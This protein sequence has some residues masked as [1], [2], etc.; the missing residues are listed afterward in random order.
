MMNEIMDKCVLVDVLD[1]THKT[2]KEVSRREGVIK[3]IQKEIS[4]K[5]KVDIGNDNS[6]YSR[7]RLD[8]SFSSYDGINTRESDV[9]VDF[10]KSR[11]KTGIVSIKDAE[12]TINVLESDITQT[13]KSG[14]SCAFA[15]KDIDIK[16]SLNTAVSNISLDMISSNSYDYVVEGDDILIGS[17]H[18]SGP[19]TL[20]IPSK[21]YMK[22]YI[23]LSFKNTSSI[24]IDNVLV[25]DSA[26]N[27]DGII[28][29]TKKNIYG[30]TS[31]IPVTTDG[32]GTRTFLG[33]L[34]SIGDIVY[35]DASLPVK[36]ATDNAHK[37]NL[38]SASSI[39]GD[40]HK[41]LYVLKQL[42][43]KKNNLD[44]VNVYRGYARF[45]ETL[46]NGAFVND[47]LSMVD[48]KP[49]DVVYKKYVDIDRTNIT[50]VAG[51]LILL[52][53]TVYVD[54]ATVIT[55]PIPSGGKNFKWR[56]AID[57]NTVKDQGGFISYELSKG[58]NNVELTFYLYKEEDTSVYTDTITQSFNLRQYSDLI[59][60]YKLSRGN[61]DKVNLYSEFFCISSDK[62]LVG[63]FKDWDSFLV[64]FDDY[65]I[66][67]YHRFS[68]GRQYVVATVKVILTSEISYVKHIYIE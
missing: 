27:T 66:S 49:S 28:T 19:L 41:G 33:L 45:K 7:N 54:K 26:N 50:L 13:L 14:S 21:H 46:I 62:V 67:P 32:Y 12:F 59:F 9:F 25:Y 35:F 36:L 37:S 52:T 16:I 24:Q 4:S 48:Y 40:K 60:D 31:I 65:I 61:I 43:G 57:G 23:R 64:T 51:D 30:S 29:T 8:V 42:S 58:N 56:L 3:D 6:V 38:T 17:G 5:P 20:V 63:S 22:L 53:Q 18:D 68:G 44:S 34:N 10:K 39:F 2:L 1:K 15:G 11:A 47:D 55:E